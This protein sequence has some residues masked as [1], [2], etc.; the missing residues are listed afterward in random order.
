MAQTIPSESYASSRLDMRQGLPLSCRLIHVSQPSAASSF[1][2]K[3]TLYKLSP[4]PILASGYSSGTTVSPLNREINPQW[5]L[6]SDTSRRSRFMGG[7]IQRS[8]TMMGLLSERYP[9]VDKKSIGELNRSAG[10]PMERP[11]PAIP[12]PRPGLPDRPNGRP[13]SRPGF[14]GNKKS[15]S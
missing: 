1:T 4:P 11:S 3:V 13:S 8:G 14:Q 5:R 10:F 9:S 15:F 7:T 2:K 6:A 12:Q